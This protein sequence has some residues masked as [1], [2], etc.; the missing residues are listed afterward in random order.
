LS[1][2]KKVIAKITIDP[3]NVGTKPIINVLR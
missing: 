3:K 1:T 2:K